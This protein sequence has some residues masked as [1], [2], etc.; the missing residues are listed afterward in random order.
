MA[1][2]SSFENV[3]SKWEPELSHHCPGVPV[4]LVGSKLDLRTN[5]A[6]IQELADKGQS[7]IA[8]DQGVH[9][10]ATIGA[11]KYMECSAMTQENLKAVFD[12]AVKRVLNPPTGAG[13]GASKDTRRTCVLF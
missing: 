6:A 10:A 4:L 12:E 7:L 1:S 5:E 13:A 11:F 3:R 8:Y 9:L 2:L